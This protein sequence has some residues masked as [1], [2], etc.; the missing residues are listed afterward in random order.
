MVAQ[1]RNIFVS[2]PHDPISVEFWENQDSGGDNVPGDKG[3][4]EFAT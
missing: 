3:I 2:I 4:A 1:S